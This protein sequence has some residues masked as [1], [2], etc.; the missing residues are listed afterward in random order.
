MLSWSKRNLNRLLNRFDIEIRKYP[1]CNFAPMP[2][3]NLAVQAL[4]RA[5]GT[6]LYFIQVGANDGVF[7]DP[8]RSF[9][10]KYQWRGILIEPQ[11]QIFELLK[12]NYRNQAE[13]LTFE[14]C[15][16][17]PESSSL[18]LHVPRISGVDSASI[19]RS[20]V[21][22]VFKSKVAKQSNVKEADLQAIQV[23]CKTLDYLLSE[24]GIDSFDVLQID[25]EG[26]DYQVLKSLDFS[27]TSPELIQFETGH[28]SVLES[29]NA[30]ELLHK[31]GYRIYWGGNQGDTVA[32]KEEVALQI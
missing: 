20:S 26:Y 32:L 27:T 31:A 4:M 17:S 2:V 18:T 28:L 10:L 15:A 11:P 21:A 16:I 13:N 19:Y 5:K 12:Q 7:G 30:A 29:R 8:L 3:L 6:Q 14:N 22:S 23:P 9:I 24:H 25:A 1:A